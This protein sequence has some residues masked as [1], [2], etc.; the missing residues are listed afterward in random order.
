MSNRILR[1]AVMGQGRSG[2]AIHVKWL[3]EARDQYQVV[4][5]ADLL[6][7][8]HEAVTELGAKGFTDYRQL[9]ADKSLGLDL[10]VN[11][12]RAT[13]TPRGRLRR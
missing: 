12:C 11:A 1:V 3:R 7:Q 5:I 9:L 10:V 4:A 13:C 8:R 6:P 2:Y